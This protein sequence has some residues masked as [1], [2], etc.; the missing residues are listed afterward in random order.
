MRWALRRQGSSV[1]RIAVFGLATAEAPAVGACYRRMHYLGARLAE[2]ARQD[3]ERLKW[4]LWHG[5]VFQALKT[6][7]GLELDLD[8]ESIN[9][10]QR[11]ALEGG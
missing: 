10:D 5:N 7:D 6:G 9:S 3:L 4:F 1:P 11:K 8:S 2:S